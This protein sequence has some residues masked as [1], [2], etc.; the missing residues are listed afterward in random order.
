[1]SMKQMVVGATLEEFMKI[2][3]GEVNREGPHLVVPVIMPLALPWSR[4]EGLEALN[5]ALREQVAAGTLKPVAVASGR[6]REPG[7]APERVQFV[8]LHDGT[9]GEEGYVTFET[10]A[11]EL[12][13]AVLINGDGTRH[14]GDPELPPSEALTKWMAGFVGWSLNIPGLYDLRY[15]F[16]EA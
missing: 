4:E 11:G 1:M 15:A 7:E 12:E 10:V 14:P 6:M 16:V 3:S 13:E 5:P 9:Q 8:L 2:A